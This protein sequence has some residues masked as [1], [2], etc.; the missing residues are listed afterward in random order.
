[1]KRLVDA[2]IARQITANSLFRRSVTSIS[3]GECVIANGTLALA[4]TAC[5]VTP[6]PQNTGSSSG[7]TG[8]GSP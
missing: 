5:G 8:T 7:L 6:Q 3:P 1:M 2:A 4:I